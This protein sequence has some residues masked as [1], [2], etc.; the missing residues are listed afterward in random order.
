MEGSGLIDTVGSNIVLSLV[1][2]LIYFLEIWGFGDVLM[3]ISLT[4]I[5]AH[6]LICSDKLLIG[7]AVRK[8]VVF[9]GC[10]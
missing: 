9:G 10:P 6:R 8:H 7:Q 1:I 5:V 2:E 3:L 4:K